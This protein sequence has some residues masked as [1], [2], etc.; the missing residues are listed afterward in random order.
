M[1][2]KYYKV[3]GYV[4]DKMLGQKSKDVDYAVEAPSYAAMRQD[5]LNRGCKIFLAPQ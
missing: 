5:I 2:I 3:G 1:T 4:R